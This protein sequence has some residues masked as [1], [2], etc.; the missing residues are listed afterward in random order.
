M[1]HRLV[2]GSSSARTDYRLPDG[3]RLA[4]K[5]I[6]PTRLP[7]T[8]EGCRWNN[9]I[10]CEEGFYGV[11]VYR[12]QA[13]TWQV[14]VCLQRMDLCRPLEA[15]TASDL[16]DEILALRSSEYREMIRRYGS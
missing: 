13:G 9:P 7:R 4:F 11:R 14:G 16:S 15:F 8:C 10:D 2:A 12:D 3:R 1:C 6:R 5:Q